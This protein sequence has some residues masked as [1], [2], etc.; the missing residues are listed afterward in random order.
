MLNRMTRSLPA[1]LAAAML[2]AA[3]AAA[4]FQEILP[5]ADMLP[6]GGEVELDMVFT[7]PFEGGPAMDMA[8]PAAAGMVFHGETTDLTGALEPLPGRGAEA[9]RLRQRLDEP[10]A[11]V[12]YVEPAPYWE[13]AEGKFIIHYSKVVVDAFGSGEGWDAMAGLPVEIMPLSQPTSLWAGNVFSG[14]VMRDGAPVPFAEIEVEFVNDQGIAA[15]NDL[16]ITQ[17][18]KADAN[19]TFTYAMPVAGW[20]GFAALVEADAPMVSPEGEEVPVELGALIWVNA[21]AVE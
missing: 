21:K 7:H 6:E 1:G 12:F 20:W 17:V 19:G 9:Y 11:A 5:S 15:P 4:H 8:P 10:G 16:Y 13:P 14:V 2:A 18:I 3:P